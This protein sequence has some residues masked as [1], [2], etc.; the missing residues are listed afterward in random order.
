MGRRPRLREGDS[1]WRFDCHHG[2]HSALRGLALLA[3]GAALLD[4]LDV[5]RGARHLAGGTTH[6]HRHGA[7]LRRR[8]H[9]EV[10]ERLDVTADRDH[11]TVHDIADAVWLIVDGLLD[12]LQEALEL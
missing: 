12:A 6:V 4:L 5:F 9:S 2:G 11:K 1:G 3:D 8:L 7:E 10:R